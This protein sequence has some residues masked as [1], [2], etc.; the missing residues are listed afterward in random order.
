VEDKKNFDPRKIYQVAQDAMAKLCQ[1][2]FEA[3][4]S[5]GQAAKIK[6]ISLEDM[7]KRY[8]KGELDPVIH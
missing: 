6:V 1:D 4:G 5:A 3:F 8:A 2:R 7:S